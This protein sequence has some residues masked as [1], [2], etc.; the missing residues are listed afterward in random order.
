VTGSSWGNGRAIA[1]ALASEGAPIV[2]SDLTSEIRAGGY[3]KDL[4]PTHDLI[5][6]THGK[7]K[8]IFQR[9]DASSEDDIK[10]LVDL[11]VK[12]YG[13]LDM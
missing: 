7:G 8:A 13:R 4:T 9:A 12:T 10:G 2:C 6:Q 5:V 11:A 3:E 1:L